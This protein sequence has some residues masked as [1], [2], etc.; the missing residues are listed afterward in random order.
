MGRRTALRPY[1]VIANVGVRFTSEILRS[2]QDDTYFGLELTETGKSRRGVL[3][4]AGLLFLQKAIVTVVRT[5]GVACCAPTQ[6]IKEARGARS[7][8]A[9]FFFRRVDAERSEPRRYKEKK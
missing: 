9:R 2:A 5:R 3:S 6:K 7:R 4:G 1:M 8:S